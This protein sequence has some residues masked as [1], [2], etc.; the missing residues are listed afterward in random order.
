MRS[1]KVGLLSRY[2]DYKTQNQSEDLNYILL[3]W[4]VFLG[5]KML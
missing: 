3:D 1:S 4:G 5:Y 2:L